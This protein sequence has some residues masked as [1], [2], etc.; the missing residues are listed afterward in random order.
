[1]VSAVYSFFLAMTLHPE[2]L[3]MAQKEIDTVVG[4]D[5]LPEFSDRENLPYVDALVKEV[6]RWNS[7]APTGIFIYIVT[8]ILLFFLMTHSVLGVPHRALEDDV[9]EGYFIPK[10]SLI[11]ANNWSVSATFGGRESLRFPDFSLSFFRQLTHDPRTYANPMTFDPARFLASENRKPELDPRQLCFG[12]G[13]RCVFSILFSSSRK[14]LT[15]DQI[16]NRICPG[17]CLIRL[18]VLK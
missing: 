13:R 8:R 7:V 11:I 1:M 4:T 10:G 2:V 3:K 9:Y 12:F 14:E 6:F 17:T 16:F 18:F 5:R 15:H